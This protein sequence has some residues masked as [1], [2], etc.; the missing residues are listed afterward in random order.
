MSTIASYWVGRCPPYL[1]RTTGFVTLQVPHLS[2]GIEYQT[3]ASLRQIG[4]GDLLSRLAVR[5]TAL[6]DR[7]VPRPEGASLMR[8]YVYSPGFLSE[9][10]PVN[11]AV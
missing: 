7:V 11:T 6:A 9:R 2:V 1:P 5:R 8:K 10:S 3:L 4:E